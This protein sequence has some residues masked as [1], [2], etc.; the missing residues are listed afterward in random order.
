MDT[1]DTVNKTYDSELQK[2]WL[3][4]SLLNSNN[5][6]NSSNT[7]F[8]DAEDFLAFIPQ[9]VL[10]DLGEAIIEEEIL[11]QLA[12]LY[13]IKIKDSNHARGDYYYLPEIGYT[14]LDKVIQNTNNTFYKLFT[15]GFEWDE[16][17][18]NY[19]NG[20]VYSIKEKRWLKS[21]KD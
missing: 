4:L 16:E 12:Q 6:F 18:S 17:V 2:Q 5:V 11:K 13:S 1:N 7:L 3:F 10:D 19:W 14:Y 20:H 9:L 8:T 21:R 15:P